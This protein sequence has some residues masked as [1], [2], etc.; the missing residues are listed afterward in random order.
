MCGLEYKSNRGG[1]LSR[2]LEI[3]VIGRFVQT[4]CSEELLGLTS[5]SL[6]VLGTL[7]TECCLSR[8]RWREEASGDR[9]DERGLLGR[10]GGWWWGGVSRG[11][12]LPV[13]SSPP[14]SSGPSSLCSLLS[15]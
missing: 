5:G 2:F 4:F 1:F 11:V 7:G 3:G 6:S 9:G 14:P 13:L 12:D 15:S 10:E 8:E